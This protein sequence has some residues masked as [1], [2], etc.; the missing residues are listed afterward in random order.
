LEEIERKRLEA[1][2]KL[3]AKKKENMNNNVLGKCSLEE[4]EKKRL[5]A[6][7]KLEAKRLQDIVEKKRQEALKKLQVNRMK[8]ASQVRSTLT[9]RL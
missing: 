2:A 8:N 5:Q 9:K 1:L 3:K 4:I 7:A 6:L